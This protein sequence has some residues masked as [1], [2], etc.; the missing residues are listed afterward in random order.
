MMWWG[1][2]LCP[3]EWTA[4]TQPQAPTT[5]TLLETQGGPGPSR[6]ADHVEQI[7]SQINSSPA[8]AKDDKQEVVIKESS[9]VQVKTEN[10]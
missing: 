5:G 8:I 6:D 2:D 9:V 4:S 3:E 10:M 1:N 7:Q